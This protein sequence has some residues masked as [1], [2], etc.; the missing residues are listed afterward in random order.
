[1]GVDHFVV[2][3]W[4]DVSFHRSVAKPCDGQLTTQA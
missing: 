1:V 3:L 2:M 4:R